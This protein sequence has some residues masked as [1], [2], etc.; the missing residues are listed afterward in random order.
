MYSCRIWPNG[1][2]PKLELI[3][4]DGLWAVRGAAA[5]GRDC[6]FCWDWPP[7][8]CS[9]HWLATPVANWSRSRDRRL[10][11]FLDNWPQSNE[12][13]NRYLPDSP[14]SGWRRPE[15]P[16][17]VSWTPSMEYR[18]LAAA[19]IP[20]SGLER[21]PRTSI[22]V[23]N[24]GDPPPEGTPRANQGDPPLVGCLDPQPEDPE[25]VRHVHSWDT[26]PRVPGAAPTRRLLFQTHGGSG[27]FLQFCRGHAAAPSSL[28]GR[29]PVYPGVHA[30]RGTAGYST[31]P[32]RD[33]YPTAPHNPAV[34][35]TAARRWPPGHR[36]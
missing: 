33:R 8:Y 10:P 3:E 7:T 4:S 23:G 20:R 18:V 26:L 35:P 21:S 14:E 29:Q 24:P 17:A 27:C 31:G 25:G 28:A 12:H 19:R 32:T 22:A 34:R 1:Q 11:S 16:I 9:A 36:A 30:P 15:S 2:I 6:R 5:D 13:S